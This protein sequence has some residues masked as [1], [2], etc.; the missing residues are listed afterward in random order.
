MNAEPKSTTASV[1]TADPTVDLALHRTVTDSS[2]VATYVSSKVVDG[3]TGTYRESAPN[4][5]PQ[6]LTVDLGS[7][8]RVS[9]MVVY[10]PP[11]S[12]RGTR[13][14]PVVVSGSANGAAW[15]TRGRDAAQPAELDVHS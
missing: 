9:T 14:Q 13:T 8:T 15:A 10:L 1:P 11:K 6:T 12:D 5:F 4:A 2:H 7:L 3:S